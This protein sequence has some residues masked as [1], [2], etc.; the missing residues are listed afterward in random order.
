MAEY[1]VEAVRRAVRVLDSMASSPRLSLSLMEISERVALSKVTTYRLLMTLSADGLVVQ[2]P[3]TKRYTLGSRLISLGQSALEAT[4]LVDV[5]TP[6]MTELSDQFRVVITL[7]LPTADA[8]VEAQRVPRHGR[9]EFVPLG[10]PIPFHACASGLVFLA[11]DDAGLRERVL[12]A[13]LERFA[14]ATITTAEGLAEEIIQVSATGYALAR[15]SLEEGVTAVAAPVF[16]RAG[17]PVA[18]IGATAPTG[19]LREEEWFRVAAALIATSDL[20][21]LRLGAEP[22]LGAKPSALAEHD[23]DPRPVSESVQLR[24][25]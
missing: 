25:L 24:G 9:G 10:A 21:S 20:V 12:A 23:V 3:E 6:L 11:N 18:T 13:G 19:A 4:N 8:V 1:I 16:D 2:D 5:A 17:N 15:D 14:S 22:R 7:N